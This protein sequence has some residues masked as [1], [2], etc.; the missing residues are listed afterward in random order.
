MGV[1][2]LLQGGCLGAARP[3]PDIRAPAPPPFP[4]EVVWTAVSDVAIVEENGRAHR[5]ARAF[6]RLDVIGQDSTGVQVR[7]GVCPGVAEGTV[8][9][10]DIL[11]AP[12]APDVAAWGSVA[13]FALAVRTAAD[14]RDLQALLPVMGEEFT[15]SFVGIQ[16]PESAIAVWRAEEFESLDQVPELL[17]RG[18]ASHDGRIWSAPPEFI[19]QPAYRGLRIGFRQRPEGRWEW[20]FLIRGLVP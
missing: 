4:S 12:L 7:C 1:L 18:L 2:L 3:A 17:D 19:D 5:L 14:R 8:D 15:Y 13:E 9:H 11:Y 16:S 6:T 10:A 20:I